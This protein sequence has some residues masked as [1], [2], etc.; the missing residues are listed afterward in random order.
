VLCEHAHSLNPGLRLNSMWALKHLMHSVDN[1]LKKQALEELESGWLVQLICDDTE[2][3]ALH[4]RLKER[5]MTDADDDEDMDAETYEDECRPWLLYRMNSSRAATLLALSSQVT[6]AEKRLAFLRDAEL[7]PIR[8]ARNDDLAIQEQALNFI[9]NLI[10]PAAPAAGGA[11]LDSAHDVTEMVD[12]VFNELGQD[13]LF[14][15]LASKLQAKVLH[16]LTRRYSRVLY[17]QARV[18]E[19]VVWLLVH[20]AASIPRHR[21]LIISQTELLKL[22]GNHFHSKDIGVRRALCH[23]L[24]NLVWQDDATDEKTCSQRAQ[25]LKRLGFLTKLEGLEQAD[26]E[27]DIRERARAAVWQMKTGNS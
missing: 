2:D 15:I 6:K 19:A 16:P 24:S 13:R 18:I 11:G 3:E 17:P 7:N 4:A 22:L 14:G 10:T 5:R 12:Y 20:V 21:Q 27:L 26:G 8:K 25:E 9:R 1:S 23:L